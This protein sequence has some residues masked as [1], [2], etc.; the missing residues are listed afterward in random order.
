LFPPLRSAWSARGLPDPVELQGGN[1][2]RVIFGALN[3]KSGHRSLLAR[4]S[5]TAID[6]QFFLWQ[7]RSEYR[8]WN[9]YLLLDSHRS[10]QDHTTE[11]LLKKM[12]IS[13]LWLP[14]R[15]PK[16]NP[17]DH[18]WGKAKEKISANWQ[19]ETID[20]AAEKFIEHI[21]M[22]SNHEALTQAGILSEKFW[23]KQALLPAF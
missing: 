16:L 11:D 9:L 7:L 15:S 22:L 14:K 2:K 19:Y 13:C 17:M 6:F 10:H 12:K 5:L 3:L 20:D 8:G 23:L 21:Q 1:A 18:L 4:P